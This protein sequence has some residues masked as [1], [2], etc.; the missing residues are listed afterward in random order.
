VKR[1]GTHQYLNCRKCKESNGGGTSIR[2]D[3]EPLTPNSLESHPSIQAT[4]RTTNNTNTNTNSLQ[5]NLTMVK[6]QPFSLSL[7][8]AP[9]V[10]LTFI[11]TPTAPRLNFHSPPLRLPFPLF[12]VFLCFAFMWGWFC[13]VHKAK[14]THHS[15]SFSKGG[16]S[17]NGCRV[18]R[19]GCSDSCIL[20]PCLQW[21][22]TPEAQ[23][24]ATV[25]V[26]KFF[27]RADLMSFIS[28]VPEAQRP[29]N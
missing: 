1:T 28:N 24:H 29:G 8:L 14:D 22:D 17:C 7:P 11:Y 10:T 6:S 9:P 12:L 26:A 15:L 20:R 21:I 25:F 4:A 13:R 27:G 23:G 3:T 18:L 19:K 5:I 16:M 2:G